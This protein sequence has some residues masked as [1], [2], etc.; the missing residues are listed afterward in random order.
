MR[1]HPWTTNFVVFIFLLVVV[2]TLLG[3]AHAFYPPDPPTPDTATLNTA[4]SKKC[5][6]SFAQAQWPKWIGCAMAKHENL[7]GGL[8][9]FGGALYAAWVAA[10]GIFR[11]MHMDLVTR[12][13]DRIE[14]VLPGLRSAL[15]WVNLVRT[16]LKDADGQLDRIVGV[17]NRHSMPTLDD[18]VRFL[19]DEKILRTTADRWRREIALDVMRMR[20]AIPHASEADEIKNTIVGIGHLHGEASEV[21]LSS[22]KGL[23]GVASRLEQEIEELEWRATS[24]REEIDQFFAS[25]LGRRAREPSAN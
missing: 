11:Q 19:E 12:E 22:V 16:Y 15:E 14:K 2:V 25:E 18:T 21:V 7:A 8:F 17:I 24:L 10:Q 9:G 13:E 4:T 1:L 5:F 23:D 3:F 20:N 6:S